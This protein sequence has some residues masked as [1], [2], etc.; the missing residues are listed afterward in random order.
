M[1][2]DHFHLESLEAFERDLAEAGFRP[3]ETANQSRWRGPIHKAFAPLT[4]A[5]TME[6]VIGS[7]W[8]FRP[9][10]L[11]VNGL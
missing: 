1:T 4:A 8:P 6:I 3:V 7:G 9:P 10:A 2:D 11:L 5:T